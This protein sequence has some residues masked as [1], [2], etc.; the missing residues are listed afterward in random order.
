MFYLDETVDE[1][2]QRLGIINEMAIPIKEYRHRFDGLR[3]QL[4]ENWCLC[5]WCQL[6]S[7]ENILF[8]HWK[9]ELRACIKHLKYID[10]KTGNK[11]KIIT[12]MFA[13]YDYDKSNMI[14]RI[15]R[16]KFN[17]EEINDDLQRNIVSEAFVKNINGI[18]DVICNDDYN[19]VDYIQLTFS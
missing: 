7:S 15:I 3:F 19:E 5:K 10:I 9:K 1:T 16:S 13:D 8:N 6:F 18:I 11:K 2:I 17:T 14:K 12:K 4:V